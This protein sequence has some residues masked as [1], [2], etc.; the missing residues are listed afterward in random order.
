MIELIKKKKGL[1]YKSIFMLGLFL[2]IWEVKIY[3][4]TIIDFIIPLL[5]ILVTG[6][7]TTPFALKDFQELFQ[8]SNKYSLYF[9]TFLQSTVSWGFTLCSLLMFSNYYLASS[10]VRTKIYNIVERSS[11]AGGKYHRDKS[12]PT[13]IIDYNGNPKQLVFSNKYYDDMNNYK[14][15][16]LKVKEGLLGFDILIE[17]KL[18]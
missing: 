5:I 4:L 7:L 16:E 1:F 14:N 9:W 8:Y 13:F 6:F 15:V 12:K 18:K 2:I 3:R 11:L 17:Q 10:D